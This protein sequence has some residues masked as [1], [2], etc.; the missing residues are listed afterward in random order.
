M[1]T[2]YGIRNVK[3]LEEKCERKDKNR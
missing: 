1:D 2:H 3:Q